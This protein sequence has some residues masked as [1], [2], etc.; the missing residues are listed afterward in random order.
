MGYGYERAEYRSST[1]ILNKDD[2]QVFEKIT[3]SGYMHPE[4]AAE[5]P[6]QTLLLNRDKVKE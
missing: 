5:L 3:P 2:L 1:L 6:E 4:I